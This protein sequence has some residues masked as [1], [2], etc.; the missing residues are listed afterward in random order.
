MCSSRAVEFELKFWSSAR[1]QSAARSPLLPRHGLTESRGER[2]T[3]TGPGGGTHHRLRITALFQCIITRLADGY[4]VRCSGINGSWIPLLCV[5]KQRKASRPVGAGI[6]GASI[7]LWPLVAHLL[8]AVA[9][10]RP[11]VAQYSSDECSWRGR[12]GLLLFTE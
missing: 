4:R 11:A 7:M 1:A 9:L 3:R 12:W 5:R 10:W 8:S 6:G 2:E